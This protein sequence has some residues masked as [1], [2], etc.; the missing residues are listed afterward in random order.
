MNDRYVHA[1]WCDDIR[2]EVGNK[3]SFMGVFT[4]GIL[5]PALPTVLPRLAVYI[6]VNTP[7][8]R[9][10]KSLRIRI[11][12]DD[13]FLLME[14]RPESPPAQSDVAQHSRPDSTRQVAMAGF[15]LGG[16]EVP[17]GCKYFSIFV[18][19]ELETLEGPKLRID[20]NPQGFAEAFRGVVGGTASNA[21]SPHS[22][23]VQD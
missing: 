12:R 1:I 5:L 11:T 18:D 13:G 23:S 4:G 14:V 8:E 17:V 3:P 10:F 21:E 19:T 6:W 15:S 2:L 20:V 16:V 22:E 7:V 9:P